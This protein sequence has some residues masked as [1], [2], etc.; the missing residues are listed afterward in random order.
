VETIVSIKTQQLSQLHQWPKCNLDSFVVPPRL[1]LDH[2]IQQQR[3]CNYREH[4]PHD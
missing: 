1:Q 4:D 3:H 2:G